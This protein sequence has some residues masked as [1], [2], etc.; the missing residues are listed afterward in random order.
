[1]KKVLWLSVVAVALLAVTAV[2]AMA[3]GDNNQRRWQ[4][5]VFGLVG[6]VTAVDA[7]ARTITVQVHTGNRLVKDYIGQ[8]LTITT[9][10]DTLFLRYED[11]KCEIIALEDVEVGAYASMNGIVI[12]GDEG[13]EIFL[14]KRVTVDVPL[15]GLI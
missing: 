3:G 8:E 9:S 5:S 6:Q 12:P 2:P 4:G 1:M 7:V 15:Q 10:E 13:N 14:A 11:P